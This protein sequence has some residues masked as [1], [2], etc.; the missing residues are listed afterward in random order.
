MDGWE[1][2][3]LGF[4][5]Q[6]RGGMEAGAEGGNMGAIAKTVIGGVIWKLNSREN[7]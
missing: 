5:D 2:G 1:D 3:S 4:K 7:C 6:T